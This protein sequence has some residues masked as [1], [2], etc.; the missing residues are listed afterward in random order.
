[1]VVLCTGSPTSVGAS[2][3]GRLRG[4]T[5]KVRFAVWERVHTPDRVNF[6]VEPRSPEDRCSDMAEG[7]DRS[8]VEAT[9]PGRD[10]ESRVGA[11]AFEPRRAGAGRVALCNPGVNGKFARRG[12]FCKGRTRDNVSASAFPVSAGRGRV[13]MPLATER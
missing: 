13:S 9:V 6:I 10:G 7:P 4:W 5:R 8:P 2:G 12:G 3:S 11:R 1:M